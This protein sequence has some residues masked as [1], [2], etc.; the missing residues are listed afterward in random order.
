MMKNLTN[1]KSSR[2]YFKEWFSIRKKDKEEK[3]NLNLKIYHSIGFHLVLSFSILLC[4]VVFIGIFTYKRAEKA[5]INQYKSSNLNTIDMT[6]KYLT[7]G[8]DDVKASVFQ[9][10]M[11]NTF[12]RLFG[13]F[14]TFQLF[15]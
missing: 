8:I 10:T 12:N 9:Y 15:R 6:S 11:D 3:A 13:D 7:L 2:N 4:F 1:N 5:M 14:N